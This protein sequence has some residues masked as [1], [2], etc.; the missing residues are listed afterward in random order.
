MFV[1]RDPDFGVV[2][3]IAPTRK[4]ELIYRSAVDTVAVRFTLVKEGV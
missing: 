4:D 3:I 1:I 2:E